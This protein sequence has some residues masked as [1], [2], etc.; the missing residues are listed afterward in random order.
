MAKVGTRK[1][2][3]KWQYYFEGASIGE[4][5]R[6]I[7]KSGFPSQK[8]AYEAGIKAM[9]EYENGG[10]SVDPKNISVD[11]YFDEWIKLYVDPNL[12]KSTKKCY[13]NL[14]NKQIRPR[15]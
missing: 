15:I 10:S 3:D 5:R 13:V 7:V 12:K 9:L 4:K 8:K 1:R 6:Q 2:G 11:D 14:I